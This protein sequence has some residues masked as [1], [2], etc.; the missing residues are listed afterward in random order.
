[1]PTWSRLRSTVRTQVRR[2]PALVV[3][4]P[5]AVTTA[6]A[7]AL[8]RRP[9]LIATKSALVPTL[10][11]SAWLRGGLQPL[12]CGATTAGWI[13]DLILLPRAREQSDASQRRQLRSGAIAF[14]IQ[15][16]GYVTLMARGGIRPKASR[17]AAVVPWLGGLSALDTLAGESSAP[18][19]IITAY[20][21][22][23]GGMTTM[24]WSSPT[25]AMQIGG[26][27]FLASDS[28]ILIREVLLK[29]RLPRAAAEAFVLGTYAAAQALLVDELGRLRQ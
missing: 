17:V 2:R 12:L 14:G 22:L 11:V 23:L 10:Q 7:G 21:V 4:V 15:Q 24:A 13:G 18:D 9:V 29:R 5:L 25:R 16:V 6:T 28:M 8:D 20:G 3:Y 27:L 26:V 1:M 19:P